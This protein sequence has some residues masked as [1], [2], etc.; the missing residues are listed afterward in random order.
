M[1][2]RGGAARHT[3]YYLLALFTLGFTALGVGQILFQVINSLFVETVY[4]Y[5]TAFDD[6]VLR[7]GITAVVIS[8]PIFFLCTKAINRELANGKL[9][10]HSLVR[11]WLTYLILFL[12]SVTIIVDLMVAFYSFLSGELTTKFILKAIVIV[13]IA[14]LVFFYYLYDINREKFLADDKKIKM[15]R[16][17]FAVSILVSLAIGFYYNTSP[18][19]VRAQREDN[20]R[21][22]RLSSIHYEIQDYLREEA[23]MPKDLE[24]IQAQLYSGDI[25]DPVTDEPFIYSVTGTASYSICANFEFSNREREDNNRYWRNPDWLHDAGKYCFDKTLDEPI[26]LREVPLP[27]SV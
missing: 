15:Y 11:K 7:F 22:N 27:P 4:T 17:I 6:E 25:T 21:V 8:A 2:E 3:F 5:D 12:S 19:A 9:D 24:V 13:A 14:A 18:G 10:L 23:A 20:E 16:N 1:S 26:K